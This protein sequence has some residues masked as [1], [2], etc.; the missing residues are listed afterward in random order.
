ME[1]AQEVGPVEV[2]T[3]VLPL[4]E[5]DLTVP[6]DEGPLVGFFTVG[7]AA[8]APAQAARV[9]AVA[10]PG[11]AG[12]ATEG[13]RRSLPLDLQTFFR[14]Y[15]SV[16]GSRGRRRPEPR[17]VG[18]ATKVGCETGVVGPA[19]VPVAPSTLPTVVRASPGRLGVAWAAPSKAP[20]GLLL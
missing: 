17:V 16:P 1:A 10:A 20:R 6:V 14:A 13:T 3:V 8:A 4:L 7:A 18:L 9:L 5:A 12:Q 2:A 19:A 15:V 11:Q